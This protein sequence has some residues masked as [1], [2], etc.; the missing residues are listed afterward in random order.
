MKTLLAEVFVEVLTGAVQ[1]FVTEKTSLIEER[2][3]SQIKEIHNNNDLSSQEK[4]YLISKENLKAVFEL[5]PYVFIEK[6]NDRNMTNLESIK[7]Y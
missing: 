5:L 6:H 2:N 3:L 1:Q 4:D 7:N